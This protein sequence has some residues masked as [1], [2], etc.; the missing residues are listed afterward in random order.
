[1]IRQHYQ[2][3]GLLLAGGL[4]LFLAGCN[5]PTSRKLIARRTEN[6]ARTTRQF[7]KLEQKRPDSLAWTLDALRDKHRED[8]QNATD[9]PRRVNRMIQDDIDHWAERQPAYRKEI[10]TQ[11][12]GDPDNIRR[13]AP[14]MAW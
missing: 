5:D 9:N 7:E 6:M 13:T 11:L 8:V 1:M 12:Q 14:R 10:R 2:T 4:A 3:T